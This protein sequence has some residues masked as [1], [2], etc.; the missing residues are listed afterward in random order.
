MTITP[1]QAWTIGGVTY[2]TGLAEKARRVTFNEDQPRD[3]KGRWIE[4]G[5]E[6]SIWGGGRGVVE[7]NVGG[8]RL[9][10]RREDDSLVRVH[11]N[12]LTVTKSA[13]GGKPGGEPGANKPAPMKVAPASADAEDFTPAQD[14]RVAVAALTPG[15]PV[16][17]YGTDQFGSSTSAV[18]WVKSVEPEDD[19][20]HGVVLDVGGGNTRRVETDP[21]SVARPIPED[22]LARLVQA[23]QDG[24]P[25]AS[26]IALEVFAAIRAGDDEE[27]T[28]S[29]GDRGAG[30]A[31][32]EP[33]PA[34]PK[35]DAPA[36]DAAPASPITEMTDRPRLPNRWGGMPTA[37]SLVHYH[38]SSEIGQTV[39]RL[40]EDAQLDVDGESL[41]N[42]LEMLATDATLGRRTSQEVLDRVKGIRDRLPEGSAAR[43]VLDFG[44]RDLDAPDTPAPQVP[45]GVPEPLRRLV[46]D[47]H[48]VPVVRR[49]PD[50]E[51]TPLLAMVGNAAQGR[52]AGRRLAREV[53]KLFNRRH[54]S[55][56]GKE[57]IDRAVRRAVQALEAPQNGDGTAP[58]PPASEPAAPAA[59]R[60]EP[61]VPEPA[62]PEVDEPSPTGPASSGEMPDAEAEQIILEAV[63]AVSPGEGRWATMTALRERLGDLPREQQDR[64]LRNVLLAGRV[65]LTPTA[66]PGNLSPEDHDAAIMVGPTP[67]HQVRLTGQPKPDLAPDTNQEPAAPV[68]A[69]EPARTPAPPAPAP[70]TP[71]P[72]PPASSGEVSDAEAERI[73]LEAVGAVSPG[74]RRWATMAALRERLGDLPREQQD[75]VLLNAMLAGRVDIEPVAIPGNLKLEDHDAA[76]MVGPTP[77]HQVRLVDGQWA[78]T[79]EPAPAPEPEQTPTPPTVAPEPA[80]SQRS[81]EISDAEAE[82]IILEAV[83]AVSPVQGRWASMT[84]LRERLGDM[85]REQQ[86]RIL[87]NAMLAR[88]VDLEPVAIMGNLKPK[89]HDAAIMVGSTPSHQVRLSAEEWAASATNPEPASAGP[90]RG[91]RVRLANGAEGE[92]TET[93]AD[94]ALVVQLDGNG[95]RPG[96]RVN[97][98]AASVTPLGQPDVDRSAEA[99]SAAEEEFPQP[100]AWITTPAFADPVRVESVQDTLTGMDV[101][102]RTV[103]GDERTVALADL[104]DWS[105]TEDPGNTLRRREDYNTESGGQQEGL[106]SDVGPRGPDQSGTTDLFAALEADDEPEQVTPAPAPERVLPPPAGMSDRDRDRLAA[107]VEEE[108]ASY[109]WTGSPGRYI[110]E[111]YAKLTGRARFDGD[112]DPAVQQWV[113]D[114]IAAHPEVLQLSFG[115][116]QDRRRRRE[117][118]EQADQRR[119]E[120]LSSEA[121]GAYQGGDYDRAL[122][123][124]DQAEQLSPGSQQWDRIREKINEARPEPEQALSDADLDAQVAQGQRRV[125]AARA[126]GARNRDDGDSDLAEAL[127]APLVAEQEARR[128]QAD[129]EEPR[130]AAP[131]GQVYADEVQVGDTLAEAQWRTPASDG[132]LRQGSTAYLNP[133]GPARLGEPDRD[134]RRVTDIEQTPGGRVKFVF[135]DGTSITRPPDELVTRGEP[136]EV[137]EGGQRVGEWVPNK[138]IGAGDRV[139]FESGSPTLPTRLDRAGL[140]LTRTER[141]TVEGRVVRR[142]PGQPTAALAEVT[143]IRSDGTRVAVDA[144]HNWRMPRRVV[145]LDDSEPAPAPEQ[146]PATGLHGGDRIATPGGP[147]VQVDA[148]EKFDGTDVVLATVR[149]DDDRRQLRA[150]GGNR[151]VQLAPAPEGEAGSDDVEVRDLSF[152]D[153]VL[154]DDAVVRVASDP[155]H[156]GERARFDIADQDGRIS[157]VEIDRRQV[158]ARLTAP[159]SARTPQR[160]MEEAVSAL[161]VLAEPVPLREGTPAGKVRLRTDQRRRLLELNLDDTNGDA[162]EGVRRA[163]A[164]L[165]ARQDLSP[166]QMQ[167]LASHLRRMAADPEQPGATRRSLARTASWIDAAYAR[168]AG[169]PV[170]P[171][172][173]GRDA[174]ERAHARNLVMGDVIALPGENGDV[175]FGHVTA[176]RPIKG[177]G[178]VQ[179]HVRDGDGTV[180]Q[181]VLP[182]G[183][184]LWVMPDLPPDRPTAPTPAVREHIRMDTLN[185][186]DTITHDAGFT[187]SVTGTVTAIDRDNRAF[188]EVE[189]YSVTV[190]DPDGAEHTVSIGDRG[191]PSVV[192]TQRGNAS[193]GQSYVGT[194]PEET[195]TSVP[196]QELRVGDRA[197]VDG[198]SGTITNII[199]TR[200]GD[201]ELAMLDDSG[202]SR[203]IPLFVGDAD[204]RDVVRLV[205]A[206]DNASARIRD[207]VRYR[208][209]V[210]QERRL[211]AFLADVEY[212]A[213]SRSAYDVADAMNGLGADTSRDA[214]LAA[215][216]ARLERVEAGDDSAAGALAFRL[217]ARDDEERAAMNDAVREVTAGLARRATS[218]VRDAL[219]EADLLPGEGWPD[220]LARTA[221][222]Y[223]DHPPAASITRAGRV[224]DGVRAR[225]R[226]SR[227]TPAEAPE[228]AP[229]PEG[230]DLA[231]RLASYRAALPEDPGNFGR[232]AVTRAVFDPVPLDQLEAGVVPEVRTITT[233]ADDVAADDGPGEQA[234]EHLAAV[235]A[236][237]RDTDVRYQR[238]LGGR[239]VALGAELDAVVGERGGAWKAA[240]TATTPDARRAAV[241]RWQNAATRE[242]ELRRL[243]AEARR[244]ALA[245]TLAEIR[246]I[247]GTGLT[248]TDR[249]GKALTSRKGSN[250]A[251]LRHVEQLLPADWL[252]AARRNGPVTVVTGPGQHNHHRGGTTI[253][254]PADN[255]TAL[256][257]DGAVAVPTSQP[258][259]VPKTTVAAH[260]LG[261]HLEATI[262]GLREAVRAL[263]WDRTSHGPVGERERP[264]PLVGEDR[265]RPFEIYPGDFPDARTGRVNGDGTHEVF[266]NVLESLAGNGDYADDDLRQWGLGVLALLGTGPGGPSGG[267]PAQVRQIDPLQG[268]NYTSL[269]DTRLRTLTSRLPDPGAQQ[270]LNAELERRAEIGARAGLERRPAEAQRT[271][272]SEAEADLDV[273][274]LSDE[275]LLDLLISGWEDYGRDP[276]ATALQ[277]RVIAEA[278]ERER[279]RARRGGDLG[280]TSASD[281]LTMETDDLANLFARNLGQYGEDASV[282]ALLDQISAELEGRDQARRAGPDPYAGQDLTGLSDTALMALRSQ[283]AAVYNDDPHSANLVRRVFAEL[284]TRDR[285]AGS[286]D[287]RTPQEREIDALIAGGWDPRDAYAEVHGLDAGEMDRQEREAL[288]D[289]QREAGERREATVRRMYKQWV[290]EQWLEAERATRGYLLSRLGVRAGI[291]PQKLWGGN[292]THA[293]AYASEELKR[294]WAEQ[295]NGGRMTYAEWRAQWL[296]DARD[297][298]DA[299]ERRNTS[300]NGKDFS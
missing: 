171:H 279:E 64:V 208:E 125:D 209:T 91:E 113:D 131:E 112:S 133:G 115:A 36:P 129:Q 1:Q 80:A 162:T 49:E 189:W 136:A 268:V 175:T 139:R 37:D 164:R 132:R 28:T 220:A 94:G 230:A 46:A 2:T 18:G 248:Y 165:R 218:R 11:R 266:A 251:A 227:T 202:T 294:W 144:E 121:F 285:Q 216:L 21:D 280:D 100:N 291:D 12:Y 198:V 182:D 252:A 188:S 184:D 73:I 65:D 204:E 145:R 157:E 155:T 246:P 232:V 203:T 276:E 256:A 262:P 194:M 212:R 38:P 146:V 35:P 82:R 89:D 23:E 239:D 176:L 108:A 101:N 66:I 156:E 86:D 56:E 228:Q 231:T 19:G 237:G 109:A 61:A 47:L 210:T 190:T 160:V 81:G 205:A 54:E 224:L 260:E 110:A 163:A 5:A 277:D 124:I 41:A 187:E 258:G 298:R 84:A 242:A 270:K 201:S 8:G 85:P 137:V 30:P 196:W 222:A 140:G 288:I 170:P 206:D 63:G 138:A 207:R 126:A 103:R 127:N 278:D 283:H 45:D 193:A 219:D 213:S 69:P 39:R 70:G 34:A 180:T 123:L 83:R 31:S 199:E 16:L 240:N 128:A 238:H 76:I 130:A 267:I 299:R 13:A 72:V 293:A 154:L 51:M 149:D 151:P 96:S 284:D 147:D 48:A 167:V 60:D 52:L 172:D 269:S 55:G 150:L 97:T 297:R 183:V 215:A 192:R 223:R 44:L 148:V 50:R 59:Q 166:D 40:G 9:E 274:A 168:L 78:A 244:D 264:A 92:V 58:A 53:L 200:T 10:I 265:G 98:T 282:T 275:D 79:P 77:N 253:S 17:V 90:Q 88:R 179:V 102:V 87:L 221:A 197:R 243:L 161:V 20:G 32:A 62:A 290:H 22:A 122:E 153:W 142:Q 114:Y 7:R 286:E 106:F 67:N 14:G 74:E 281:L 95:N 68:P 25:D 116:R 107:M 57:E 181:R 159:T 178:L 211:T 292:P 191:W 185:I 254:L 105:V 143:L 289:A 295:P 234:M 226:T 186:G 118:R 235:R 296:G 3:R 141:L 6:V 27:A 255:N 158:V 263:L 15:Q 174:P 43:R 225:L 250:T 93:G 120:E 273:T 233:W 247:G 26:A 245:A 33:Q 261:H 152:G 4:T 24:S 177:F 134:S 169:F 241:Q 42:V 300:G 173:P 287:T 117:A 119:A 271:P 71:D 99:P 104:G 236:A 217:G 272:Q 195:P 249:T 259:G 29:G 135:D 111:V 229:L 75:R 214:A 257:P